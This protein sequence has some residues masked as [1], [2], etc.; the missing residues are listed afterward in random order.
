MPQIPHA[1]LL[2]QELKECL[3]EN[4]SILKQIFNVPLNE[5]VI[6]REYH[7]QQHKICIVFI[8]GM[9]NEQ[10]IGEFILH[11][12]KNAPQNAE[13]SSNQKPTIDYFSKYLLETAQ[14]QVIFD[15]KE[16]VSKIVAGMVCVLIEGCSEALIIEARNYPHRSVDQP[17][18]EHVVNGSHE[19]FNEHLRTN[20][21]LI[22]RYVQSPQL[23]TRK[24]TVGTKVPTQL[25]VVYL[26]GVANEKCVEEL[27]R[28]MKSINAATVH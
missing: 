10:R 22:R 1:E 26:E 28:R 24:L 20:I 13:N 11:A 8:E 23:I 3:D 19:A 9:S 16:A 6:F 5:D 12:V 18:G 25:G 15:F 14:A 4:I 2:N 21:S 7:T 17:T 27:M